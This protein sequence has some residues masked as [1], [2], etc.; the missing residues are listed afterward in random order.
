MGTSLQSKESNKAEGPKA[1]RA[2]GEIEVPGRI[3]ALDYGRRRI[4]VAVS[5]ELRITARPMSIIERQNRGDLMRKI[6]AMA[7]ELGARLILVGHPLNLDGTPGEMAEEA[8]RFASRVRKELGMEV[9]LVDERLT[10]WVAD[11][12]AAAKPRGTRREGRG[13]R[14]AKKSRDDVAAAIFLRDYIERAQ[15]QR[16][17]ARQGEE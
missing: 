17:P 6:R 16:D 10:S 5:D 13:K 8:A 15:L 1:R 2:R 11:Q 9:E 12:A 7:R 3:L 14:Q 4:G